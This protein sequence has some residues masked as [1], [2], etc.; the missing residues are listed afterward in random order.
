LTIEQR[1]L[2][3]ENEAAEFLGMSVATLRRHRYGIG[4]RHDGPPVVK[5][6]HL[7]R[8]PLGGLR[9][10]IAARQHSVVGH[11]VAA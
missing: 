10:Y 11:R 3:N 8:Y 2:L 5:I 1:E 9:G 6:G 4:D 7:V